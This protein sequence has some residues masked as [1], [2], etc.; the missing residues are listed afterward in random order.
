MRMKLQKNIKNTNIKTMTTL[1]N[2][3]IALTIAAITVAVSSGVMF[4]LPISATPTA[5]AQT[6]IRD[7]ALVR[8]QNTDDVYIVKI[9]GVKTFKRLILNP[10]IFDSYAHLSW[11]NIIDVSQAT[12]NRY[13]TSNLV[14]EV[15]PN[16]VPVDGKV[17]RLESTDG[18]DAGT[19]R[20]L[21]L[22][23]AEFIA[24]DF[25][26]DSIYNINHI[27]ASGTFYRQGPD[28]TAGD[29][30]LTTTTPTTATATVTTTPT[31]TT[32]TTQPATPSTATPTTPA[33]PQVTLPTMPTDDTDTETDPDTDTPEPAQSQLTVQRL[34]IGGNIEFGEEDTLT[35]LKAQLSASDSSDLTVTRV[36]VGLQPLG[37]EDK[38]DNPARTF[39]KIEL[40]VGEELV[41]RRATS[42]TSFVKKGNVYNILLSGVNLFSMSADTDAE[43]QIKL[44]TKPVIP[45]SRYQSW[46]IHLQDDAIRATNEQ[47]QYTYAQGNAQQEFVVVEEDTTTTPTNRQGMLRVAKNS[48]IDWTDV[49]PGEQRTVMS[50]NLTAEDSDISLS[51]LRVSLQ[52]PQNADARRAIERV[53][54]Y[55]DGSRRATQTNS[56]R[57]S[58]VSYT[59]NV[60]STENPLVIEQGETVPLD[61][62]VVTKDTLHAN[63]LGTW[64]VRLA[65]QRGLVY[66]DQA[67]ETNQVA[68]NQTNRFNLVN[69]ATPAE[70]Q[71][72]NSELSVE[73]I[74]TPKTTI[75]SNGYGAVLDMRFSEGDA[76]I[77]LDRIQLEFEARGAS[78]TDKRPW[79]SFD[80]V[81]IV[82]RAGT[83]GVGRTITSHFNVRESDF[84]KSG[85][86][87]T[88]TFED[89]DY[90]LG[91]RP[92]NSVYDN[93]TF[94]VRVW[95][96]SN[97]NAQKT[98]DWVIRIPDGGVRG[99]DARNNYHYAGGI[100]STF[101]IR[102]SQVTSV[103]DSDLTLRRLSSPSSARVVEGS[104]RYTPVIAVELDPADNL[105]TILDSA[106]DETDDVFEAKTIKVTLEAQGNRD[107]ELEPWETFSRMRLL[108]GE[109]GDLAI[110]TYALSESNFISKGGGSYE[111]VFDLDNIGS[112]GVKVRDIRI[113]ENGTRELAVALRT[114][115]H[116]SDNEH[117]QEWE[118]RFER[119]AVCGE[120]GF[121][122]T[123]CA[124]GTATRSFEVDASGNGATRSTSSTSTRLSENANRVVHLRL[125]SNTPTSRSVK[126]SNAQTTNNVELLKFAVQNSR[127]VDLQM[128]SMEVRL[129]TNAALN[130]VVKNV[131]LYDSEDILLKRVAI[132][133][134]A[135]VELVSFTGL[136]IDLNRDDTLEF[137]VKV[138]VKPL[139]TSGITLNA[140]ATYAS[141]DRDD[142]GVR[143]TATGNTVTFT[144][145]STPVVKL[146]SA[147]LRYP[148]TTQN[149][150]TDRT[151]I[152]ATFVVDVTAQGGDIYLP[153]NCGTT[154]N[155]EIGFVMAVPQLVD[156]IEGR[157]YGE[158]Q[159]VGIADSNDRFKIKAGA[160]ARITLRANI[161]STGTQ[162]GQGT[163][164]IWTLITPTLTQ[165]QYSE[166]MTGD[167]ETKE[168]S[169]IISDAT[170][171]LSKNWQS[172]SN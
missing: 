156:R 131:E 172:A 92:S 119:N 158:I 168:L 32:T 13:Q 74:S 2:K 104:T 56:A 44:T 117:S 160:T 42:T 97:L 128:Q 126:A 51:T 37:G 5:T 88:L 62:K 111:I 157:N 135:Q 141:F 123:I 55:F 93:L 3:V 75:S 16:G 102:G 147:T 12:L 59:F 99:I 134:S 151:L 48:N 90:A 10:A 57:A 91:G 129:T 171:I 68:F 30:G 133:S 41:S 82:I 139:H 66:R 29:F 83:R 27:E 8:V 46:K 107:K 80:D 7:G 161:Q 76:E 110:R 20:W 98:Q 70:G 86:K 166:T 36:N 127:G 4:L 63:D 109:D 25:D 65:T 89:M 58:S 169:G 95:G 67:G 115:T 84:R 94:F 121:E 24:T 79:Q 72:A 61:I 140:R 54:L 18:S 132:D 21:K 15:Y 154:T 164:K 78:G 142:V 170:W 146:S 14:R 53:N 34:N 87:Y 153:K 130:S 96:E 23:E 64:S 47:L 143:G 113:P 60:A 69:A 73:R 167:L 43:I 17:F 39:D 152:T 120:D 1:T 101:A 50:L 138:D 6:Q 114:Y 11:D 71:D 145:T 105:F 162:S 163:G 148:Q 22:T 165:M 108:L 38:D 136:N 9:T 45:T 118:I 35:V 19:K 85:N 52:G 125:D 149:D 124:T 144:T 26:P 159:C 122:R 150:Q 28:L 100:S 40:F 81:Q 106:G 31:S 33:T 137:S 49:G 77:K 103:Q 112:N 116:L 155:N